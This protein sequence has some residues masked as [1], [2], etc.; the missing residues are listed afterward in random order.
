MEKKIT[1]KR[2]HDSVQDVLMAMQ[3]VQ[4]TALV[5]GRKLI[6]GTLENPRCLSV[7]KR[8]NTYEN[9]EPVVSGDA[10]LDHPLLSAKPHL[11]FRK[12]MQSAKKDLVP[13]T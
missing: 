13:N 8:A 6:V 11:G 12:A 10:G 4:I 3:T 1:L 5:Q 2:D 7:R 9:K